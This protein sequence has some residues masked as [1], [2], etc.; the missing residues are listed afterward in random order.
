M[1]DNA[2]VVP[3]HAARMDVIRPIKRRDLNVFFVFIMLC[4]LENLCNLFGA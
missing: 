2:G 1:L 4:L 3:S